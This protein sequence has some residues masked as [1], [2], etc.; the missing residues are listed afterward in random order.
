MK[1]TFGFLLAAP[2]AFSLMSIPALAQQHGGQPGGGGHVNMGGHVG[3][4]FIPQHGPGPALYHG[5][6]A[7]RAEPGINPGGLHN[8]HQDNHGFRDQPGHPDAPHVHDSGQ[9]IGHQG[10]DTHY[11]LDRPWE[12]GHFP[13]NFGPRYVYRLGGGGPDRFF[14]NG[15]YFGVAPYDYGYVDG[16]NWDADDIIIYDD[17]SDPGWYLAYNPRLG[18]YVHVQYLGE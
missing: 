16:W 2:L 1:H 11:H 4:G 9:W 3:G 13:G 14:F 5:Q 7:Q 17:P 18:T 8:D 6:P 10:G 12:H 15:F